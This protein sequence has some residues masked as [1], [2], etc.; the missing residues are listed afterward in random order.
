MKS[1][2]LL[3]PE[4]ADAALCREADPELFFPSGEGFDTPTDEAAYDPARAICRECPVQLACLDHALQWREPAG[5]WGG[6]SPGARRRI[7][8]RRAQAEA[9]GQGVLD[10]GAL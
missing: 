1:I 8:R 10:V 9:S 5:M 6:Q 2:P 4:V 7:L 3:P